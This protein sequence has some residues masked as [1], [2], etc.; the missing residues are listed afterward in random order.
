M[1]TTTSLV[2]FENVSL[3]A[4]LPYALDLTDVSLELNAGE[5]GLVALALIVCC[6]RMSYDNRARASSS[7]RKSSLNS[8]NWYETS[9]G[10]TGP[11]DAAVTEASVGHETVQ[12]SDTSALLRPRRPRAHRTWTTFSVL[13]KPADKTVR[14]FFTARITTGARVPR[15]RSSAAMCSAET[16]PGLPS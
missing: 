6:G 10:S 14:G 1:T 4:Q 3:A 9:C 16:G 11:A 5:L 13:A 2:R 7:S 12:P 8:L 15:S